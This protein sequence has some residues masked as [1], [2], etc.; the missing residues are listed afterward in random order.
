M[1]RK[2]YILELLYNNSGSW[3]SG[4]EI[5]R[6]LGI[7]RTAVWKHINLLRESG[8]NIESTSSHGHRLISPV[9]IISEFE[10]TRNLKTELFGRREIHVFDETDS[11]NIQAFK[12]ASGG[13]AEGS[14]VT[15]ESQTGGKGRLGRKWIS[16]SGTNLYLSI[17]VRPQISILYAP[18]L[19]LV[20]AVALSET[21]DSLGA[22]EHRIKWP[23]DILFGD[24][25]I[26][27]ILTEMKGDC[28]SIDFIIIGVGIN[29]NT[30]LEQYP[31]EIKDS[32]VSLEDITGH[33]I[34]RLEFL[35]LFLHNFERNYLNFIQGNF[36]LILDEWIQKSSIINQKIKVTNHNESF[37]GTVT[38]V[39]NDGNL[40]VRTD[41]GTILVNSGDVNYLKETAI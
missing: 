28:D 36:P 20:T 31:P 40:L 34:N 19:T 27:G 2:N 32:V 26:S 41:N 17:I 21:F 33:K 38:E 14:I 6:N 16:P 18:R 23:N 39:T 4:E 15:A 12:I 24:K 35:T 29:L 37:T 1:D 25:K 13:A 3:L 9:E 10:I 30:P 8:Y 11:S 22:R 5:S 7:S